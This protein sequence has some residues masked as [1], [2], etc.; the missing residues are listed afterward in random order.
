MSNSKIDLNLTG[1][2]KLSLSLETKQWYEGRITF[3]LTIESS[4]TKRKLVIVNWP[5][6]LTDEWRSEAVANLYYKPLARLI[7]MHLSNILSGGQLLQP[8]ESIKNRIYMEFNVDSAF[9]VSDEDKR[10]FLKEV[11]K[12]FR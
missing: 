7:N 6:N 11:G 8:D 2:P 10:K 3:C 1:N 4:D 5:K 12:L 9:T